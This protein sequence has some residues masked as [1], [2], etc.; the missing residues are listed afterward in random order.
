MTSRF[1]LEGHTI[2]GNDIT[3]KAEA[4]CE[5]HGTFKQ[6]YW[7]QVNVIMNGNTFNI[8]DLSDSNKELVIDQLPYL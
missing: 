4:D 5:Q 6:K 2:S 8:D 7:S 3:I 1:E